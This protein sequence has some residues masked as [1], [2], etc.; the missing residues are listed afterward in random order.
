MLTPRRWLP[1][2]MA[3]AF[4][5][6]REPTAPSNE[7]RVLGEVASLATVD[8]GLHMLQ[9]APGAPPLETYQ[10]SF[11]AYQGQA[12][13]VVVHYQPAAGD[14]VGQPFLQF[15]I[16]EDGLRAGA[17]GVRL[18]QG[19]SVY[20]TLT[21]DSVTFSVNFQPSGV[22]FSKHVPAG[23]TLWYE[24]ANPDLNG[25]GVVDATDQAMLLRLAVWCRPVGTRSWLRLS[26]NND[27][28][29]PSISTALYHFSEYAVSW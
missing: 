7:P 24:N 23:L 9:Q 1:L 19:D 17:D 16:P 14:T 20:V 27:A 5:G 25:D 12:S 22:E 26:S 15:D 8:S 11:W 21:I 6:C 18:Q 10:V 13:T 29:L 4:V 28:T 2:A 3:L